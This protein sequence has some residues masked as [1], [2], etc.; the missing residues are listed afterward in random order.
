MRPLLLFL[1][2]LR[3][4]HICAG[5]PT[6]RETIAQA[7]QRGSVLRVNS[8]NQAYDFIHPWSKDAPFARKGLGVLIDGSKILVTAEL[9]ANN[10]Y[11]EV[12]RS[13]GEKAT[14]KI[15]V[16]DYEANLAT[17]T[18]D[19]QNFLSGMQA[20]SVAIDVKTGDELSVLQ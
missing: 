8:T 18:V 12:V 3:L 19:D 6:P 9:V 4:A 7:E 11:I 16:I 10:D 15:D 2:V 5:E 13:G 14:A 1:V 20:L 17:L